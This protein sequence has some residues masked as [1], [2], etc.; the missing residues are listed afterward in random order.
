[1]APL[2]LNASRNR[3]TVVGPGALNMPSNKT[4][5]GKPKEGRLRVTWITQM[6]FNGSLANFD[7]DVQATQDSGRLLA[8]S[9]QV[10]MDRP[11]DFKQGQRGALHDAVADACESE[12]SKPTVRLWHRNSFQGPAAVLSRAYRRR[13]RRQFGLRA[14]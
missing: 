9:M 12:V 8:Q 5:D 1:M 2:D 10:T 11:V 14:R 3:A 7:G 4:L 13:E 6:I